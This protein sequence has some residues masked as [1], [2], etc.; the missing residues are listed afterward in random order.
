MI[1]DKLIDLVHEEGELSTKVKMVMYF[2]FMFRDSRYRDFICNTVG[3]ADGTWD[4]SIFR[5]HQR[6]SY[7]AGVGG[8]KAFTNLRQFLFQ[9]GVLDEHTFAVRFPELDKWFPSA[10][11]IAAQSIEDKEGRKEFLAS[12]HGFLIRYKINA[13][14]NSTAS[15][16]A[17]MR[18]GGTY[19]EAENL[20]PPIELDERSARMDTSDF[21][22]W[23]RL[24][25]ARRKNQDKYKTVSDPVAF[26]RA[27]YQHFLLEKTVEALCRQEGATCQFN[28]HIDLVAR[29]GTRS[30]VF[31]MKSCTNASVRSQLR[32]AVSQ[33]LEYRYLYREKL[34]EDVR[35]CAVIERCPRHATEWMMGY[36]GHLNI[37]LIWKNDK[38][39][40]LNCT[41]FTD[42]LLGDLLP[43]IK[44]PDFLASGE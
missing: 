11:E 18:L 8:R 12:P 42:N 28:R 44:K 30:V 41:P 36:L 13:L 39:D 43:K 23:N 6:K 5:N 10:V 26:E 3:R 31:E 27:N 4:T 7:F 32:R 1:R 19:E 29:F 24:P 35:L 16:L 21:Q 17:G 34:G 33:L 40:K 20:L 14:L 38:N 22:D 25:P 9:I 37:G 2:L 15:A